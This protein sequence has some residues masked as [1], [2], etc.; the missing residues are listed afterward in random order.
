M[1]SRARTNPTDDSAVVT[2][3]TSL[4]RIV[5]L[6]R[7]AS[8]GA[9]QL[10]GVSGAQVFVMHCLGGAGPL[11]ISELAARTM[12]HQ[13]SVSVVVQRLVDRGLVTRGV[14]AGDRRRREVTLTA[15]GRR[16]LRRSPDAAQ[17]RL[18]DGLAAL[19]SHARR[20]LAGNLRSLIQAMGVDDDLAAAALDGGGD[21]MGAHGSRAGRRR[22]GAAGAARAAAAR[23]P[24]R[25][26]AAIVR[27]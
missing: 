22:A 23:R 21:S 16:L 14:A 1:Q 25:P 13:S 10:A 11:T 18:L 19:S 8:R 24:R 4:R 6:I 2:V 3:M 26:T 5:R 7:E 12:T 27:R 15:A 9:E 17:R 20:D